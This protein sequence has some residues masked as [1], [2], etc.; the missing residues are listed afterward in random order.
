M[1][2]ESESD[3]EGYTLSM[4]SWHRDE[5]GGAWAYAGQDCNALR[6]AVGGEGVSMSAFPD[7]RA[8]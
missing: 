2:A 3:S 6:P 8:I 4:S 7:G 5:L 1:H